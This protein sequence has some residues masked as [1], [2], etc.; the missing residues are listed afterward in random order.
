MAYGSDAARGSG[1]QSYNDWK[2]KNKKK[3]K[4]RTGSRGALDQKTIRPGGYGDI[5]T[6]RGLL[7]PV[8]SGGW[9]D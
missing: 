5:S 4:Y 8:P 1:G 9:N 7:R 6:G 3:K 2:K